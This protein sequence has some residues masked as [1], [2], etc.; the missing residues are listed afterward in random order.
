MLR[1]R[2]AI[3]PRDPRPLWRQIEEGI[4]ERIAGSALAAGEVVPS[5]RELALELRVNPATV[6]KAFQRLVDQG[7]LE[8][9][10][11]DG[12]YVAEAP[13]ALRA[14]ERRARLV[15][16]A[17]RLATLAL[18]LGVEREEAHGALDDALRRLASSGGGPR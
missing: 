8:T 16:A 5:V 6:A 13:P 9:R 10:R 11:G 17:T 3:D 1:P 4:A 12:T 18:A 2:L 7:L 15:A 14:A